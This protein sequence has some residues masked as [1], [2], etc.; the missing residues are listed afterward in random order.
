MVSHLHS[1]I[2][3][4]AY[5]Y[6]PSFPLIHNMA[7][8]SLCENNGDK[9]NIPSS[10]AKPIVAISKV[11]FRKRKLRLPL[12]DI[13][14]FYYPGS[15][16]QSSFVV[17]SPFFMFLLATLVYQMGKIRFRKAEAT[18]S[19]NYDAVAAALTKNFR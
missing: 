5:I 8:H 3:T 16:Q 14:N 6:F 18:K 13:T 19:R 15:F 17:D 7:F 4:T 12:E 10:S 2:S 9:E 1:Q 11:P